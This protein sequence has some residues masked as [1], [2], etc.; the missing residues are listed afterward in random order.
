[1]QH[2]FWQY[3]FPNDFPGASPA[4]S[5]IDR[6]GR[7]PDE[8]VRYLDERLGRLLA[9]YAKEPDVLIVSDHGAGPTTIPSS[10]RGWHAQEGVFIAA[11][12]SIPHSTKSV[13]VSY[14]DVVPTIARL[15]GF[16]EPDVVH[17]RALVPD[18]SRD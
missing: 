15:K 14:Y 7:V 12:P 16:R 4:Q 13:S 8:Y 1:V 3:R 5:D 10:W 11:G 18:V 2:A 17:G 9:L 6:L